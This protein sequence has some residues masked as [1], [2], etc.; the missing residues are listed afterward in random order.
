MKAKTGNSK[1]GNKKT[2]DNR[3]KLGTK[4]LDKHRQK[5]MLERKKKLKAALKDFEVNNAPLVL[6]D[7]AERSG[8]SLSTLGRSPYKEMIKEHE[9]EAKVRLSPTGKREI[10]Q[11]LKRIQ[12]LETDL[13]F[14]KEKS[15]RIEKE[16][17]FIK[18]LMLR[19]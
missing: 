10:S 2:G 14:E 12:Q 9:E 19:R 17:V 18:E 16:F 11:L 13:V 7:V 1:K 5:G 8:I 3:G 4:N 6:V 15:K